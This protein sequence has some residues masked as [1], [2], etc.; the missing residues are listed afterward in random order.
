[1]NSGTYVNHTSAGTNLGDP[2]GNSWAFD[3][4]APGAGGGDVTFYLAGNAANGNFNNQG[5]YIY[6]HEMVASEAAPALY[7]LTTTPI[8][9]TIPAAGGNITYSID[10]FTNIP[11]AYNNVNYWTTATLPDNTNSGV[12]F[13]TTA[14]IPPFANINIPLMAQNIP[15][16]APAGVY[17]HHAMMGFFPNAVLMDSF[18]F[19]KEGGGSTDSTPV[20]NWDATG[21][22][23]GLAGNGADVVDL[24]SE[25]MLNAAYPN[26]FNAMTNVSVTLPEASDLSLRVINLVGEEVATLN[27]GLVSAGSHTFTFNAADLSSGTY[28]VHAIVSGKMSQVQRVTLVK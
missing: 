27:D 24:P 4:T 8:N 5:D 17:T 3:W 20:H 22:W 16:F 9:D 18:E 11:Q 28:F 23:P 19:F 26:P 10:F 1:L 2:N 14:N 25:Y 13:S 12:L 15:S 21:E 6:S 7:G